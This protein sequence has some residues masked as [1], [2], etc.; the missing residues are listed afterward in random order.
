M[1]TM[2]DILTPVC[3]LLGITFIVTFIVVC[4]RSC[5]IQNRKKRAIQ[6]QEDAWAE[7]DAPLKEGLAKM[8]AK[9]GSKIK[10]LAFGKQMT[11]KP[12]KLENR[13]TDNT[14]DRGSE[15]GSMLSHGG[16]QSVS[17]PKDFWKLIN[18]V[19]QGSED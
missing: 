16:S 6:E 14:L 4:A 8:K 9:S 18:D 19:R 5:R 2:D 15:F 3:L 17:S 13:V 12:K 11:K 7:V 10:P 1:G